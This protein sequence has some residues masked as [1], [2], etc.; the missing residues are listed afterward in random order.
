MRVCI[1]IRN[2]LILGAILWALIALVA[3][4][5]AHAAVVNGT[6]ADDYLVGTSGNDSIYG[7]GGKDELHG[8]AGNDLLDGGRGPDLLE[9]AG[10]ADHMIGGYGDDV[11]YAWGGT[12]GIDYVSCGGGNDW[13]YVGP[14]DD[15]TASCE[16]VEVLPTKTASAAPEVIWQD[17]FDADT[18][19]W[20]R[21]T[22]CPEERSAIGWLCYSPDN[23]WTQYGKLHLRQVFNDGTHCCAYPADRW[24]LGADVSTFDPEL[25]HRPAQNVTQSFE[26]PVRIEARIKFS[27]RDGLWQAFTAWSVDRLDPTEFDIAEFRGAK[28]NSLLTAVHYNHNAWKQHLGCKLTFNATEAFHVYWMEVTRSEVVFGVDGLACGRTQLADD[29]GRI[30]IDFTAKSANPSLFPWPGLGGPVVG[31]PSYAVDWVRAVKP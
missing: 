1:G 26:P 29:P 22:N 8:K 7:K 31:T 11:L 12:S 6:A 28:E 14:L 25:G 17:D 19:D 4:G 2:G 13:A 3:V 15:A 16:H 20:I 27:G 5:I 18:P 9:G 10:G 21:R 30:G 24:F 23:V